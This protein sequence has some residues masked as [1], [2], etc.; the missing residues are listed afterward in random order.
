MSTIK[1]FPAILKTNV[2]I[3]LTLIIAMMSL[4]SCDDLDDGLN[5]KNKVYVLKIEPNVPQYISS[6]YGISA[7]LSGGRFDIDGAIY[8]DQG[9]LTE[10]TGDNIGID[11]SR[12][13]STGVIGGMGS[14]VKFMLDAMNWYKAENMGFIIQCKRSTNVFYKIAIEFGPNPNPNGYPSAVPTRLYYQRM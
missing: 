7:V 1:K 11:T 14:S 13:P 10:L 12:V 2:F 8:Y 5:N 9:L 6:Y 3:A 4:S